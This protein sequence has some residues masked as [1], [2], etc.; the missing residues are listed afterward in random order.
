MAMRS[1]GATRSPSC[2]RRPF[3]VTR[4]STTQRSI[5]RRD[6][7]PRSARTF[8][9]RAPVAAEA[10]PTRGASRVLRVAGEGDRPRFASGGLRVPI[11]LAADA[12]CFQAFV[13]RRLFVAF[14]V[15]ASARRTVAAQVRYRR[16]VLSGHGLGEAQ[17]EGDAEFVQV[18]QLRER[19]QLIEA[20][21]PEV[22]EELARRAVERGTARDIAM[23][24]GAHPPPVE[25]RTKNVRAQTHAAHVLDLATR[26]RLA[27][28]DDRE[29]LEQRARITRRPLF[30]QPRYPL[31]VLSPD[32]H[33]IAARDLAQL[34]R[35]SLVLLAQLDERGAQR[36]AI[37]PLLLGEQREQLVE[38]E[39]STGSE[40]RGFEDT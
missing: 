12:L 38:V 15:P 23:S 24:N 3:T 32:L 7:S 31:R 16:A 11:G 14:L 30:P 13:P 29:C 17:L 18:A 34:H 5:S 40:Q 37:R 9:R 19:R 6:P 33:A 25:Q 21:Q 39:R 36:G 27:I 28:R 20:P 4:A 8:W 22:V 35:A 1:P 26:D 10:A 2:A